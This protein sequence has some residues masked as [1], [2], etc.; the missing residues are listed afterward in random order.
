MKKILR[1]PWGVGALVLM[2]VY[3]VYQSL[4]PRKKSS[5]NEPARMPAPAG[6]LV[7]AL[8]QA[9]QLADTL[10]PR[11]ISMVSDSALDSNAQDQPD[12]FRVMKDYRAWNTTFQRDPFFNPNYS[13]ALVATTSAHASTR[14]GIP[15]AYRPEEMR[16]KA[17]FGDA[18]NPSALLD[19]KIVQKGDKASGWLVSG[20]LSDAV[21]L[22]NGSQS[23]R[24]KLFRA[25]DGS[26]E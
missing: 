12:G 7:G 16:L 6:S 23:Y 1:S 17:I 26:N 13:D 25:E 3:S 19:D 4:A 15:M 22:S 11:D 9:G 20:I 2:A 18:A 8:D 21:L 5:A 24:L 10:D 14:T